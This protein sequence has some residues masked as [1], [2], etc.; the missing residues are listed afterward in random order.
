M[1]PRTESGED[2]RTDASGDGGDQRDDEADE[3]AGVEVAEPS[4]ERTSTQP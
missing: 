4:T 3:E 2:G 1:R